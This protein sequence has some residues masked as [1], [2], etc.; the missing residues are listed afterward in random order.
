[1]SDKREKVMREADGSCGPFDFRVEGFEDGYR[2]T[3]HGDRERIRDGRR[4]SGAFLNFLQQ[5]DRVGLRLPFPFRMLLR[6]W[7]RYNRRPHDDD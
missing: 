5:A 1:M 6:F 7:K 4:V 3:F 2:L